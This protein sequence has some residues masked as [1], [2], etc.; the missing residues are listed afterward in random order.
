MKGL[1]FQSPY[2]LCKGSRG[3]QLFV[4]CCCSCEIHMLPHVC[5][6]TQAPHKRIKMK[7]LAALI[8]A[9]CKLLHDALA[10]NQ[11]QAMASVAAQMLFF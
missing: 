6:L 8:T 3:L 9:V 2:S 11:K 4:S 7:P 10:Y 5:A 1:S